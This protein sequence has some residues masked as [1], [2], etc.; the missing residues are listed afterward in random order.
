LAAFAKVS[1]IHTILEVA[2]DLTL[3]SCGDHLSWSTKLMKNRSADLDVAPGELYH[4]AERDQIMLVLSSNRYGVL[5]IARVVYK[6]LSV[7]FEHFYLPVT[8][9]AFFAEKNKLC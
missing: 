2:K 5:S 8:K 9:D 1:L 7:T 4:D 3:V 6:R